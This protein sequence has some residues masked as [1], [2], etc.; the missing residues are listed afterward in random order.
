MVNTKFELVTGIEAII[1][2]YIHNNLQIKFDHIILFEKN[3]EVIVSHSGNV[4]A[5]RSNLP[6]DMKNMVY[7]DGVW[8]FTD[9]FE[10]LNEYD[11][12]RL[13]VVCRDYTLN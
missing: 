11:R 12:S 6:E 9:A 5:Y 2:W 13:Q 10:E 7:N 1:W 8:R 4:L 3:L